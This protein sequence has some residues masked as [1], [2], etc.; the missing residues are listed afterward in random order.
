MASKVED[1]LRSY[2]QR[3]STVVRQLAF[4]GIAIIWFMHTSTLSEGASPTSKVIEEIY[5]LPLVL[6]VMTL[7]IDI[8]QYLIGI[9]LWGV[10]SLR[11][12]SQDLAKDHKFSAY[13]PVIF[14]FSKLLTLLYAYW[15]LLYSLKHALFTT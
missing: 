15:L 14:I 8:F 11:G 5:H 4:A 13:V 12:Y 3:A 1:L 2:T 9:I 7:T 10:L 6:Y